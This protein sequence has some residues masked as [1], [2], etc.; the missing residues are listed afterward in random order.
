MKYDDRI[1]FYKQGVED[2]EIKML[3]IPRIGDVLDSEFLKQ[4]CNNKA[5]EVE[6]VRFVY[7]DNFS[8]IDYVEIGIRP[9]I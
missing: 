1:V 2:V 9:T 7:N 8:E 6:T 4:K 5:C 3:F